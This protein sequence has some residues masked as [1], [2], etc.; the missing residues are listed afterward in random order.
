MVYQSGS[1]EAESTLAT[2]HPINR[3]RTSVAHAKNS[4]GAASSAFAVVQHW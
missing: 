2:D 1:E 4:F 3:K